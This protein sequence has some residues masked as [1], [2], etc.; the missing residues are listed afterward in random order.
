MPNASPAVRGREYADVVCSISLNQL[1]SSRKPVMPTLSQPLSAIR[2]RSDA[3]LLGSAPDDRE[4]KV[5][6]AGDRL[7]RDSGSLVRAELPH[8][9]RP[10]R[11][12]SR[13][14][15]SDRPVR[16]DP[17]R[18]PTERPRREDGGCR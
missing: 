18:R 15:R 14:S 10:Q 5:R 12:R 3:G 2:R 7:D 13:G 8:E 9:Q 4:G 1:A 16:S 6:L 11:F 17:D